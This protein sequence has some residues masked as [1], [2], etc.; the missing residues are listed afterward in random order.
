NVNKPP[1][2]QSSRAPATEASPSP[3]SAPI[4]AEDNGAG[5]QILVGAIILVAI[6]GGIAFLVRRRAKVGAP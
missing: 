2:P 4:P 1:Q 5:L 6:S 3:T